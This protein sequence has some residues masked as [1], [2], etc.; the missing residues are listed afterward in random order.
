MSG[1]STLVFAHANGYP[2]G[3]YRPLLDQLAEH[4]R[5][6]A[7]E[8]R[9]LWP[10]ARP[11]AVSTWDVFADDW[12]AWAMREALPPVIGVGH[13]IGAITLLQ[14]A[15]R[16]PERFTALVLLDPVLFTPGRHWL[17]R[18]VRA[19]GLGERLHPLVKAT[20]KR[21]RHFA[22]VA[23]MV[24]RYRRVS[25]FKRIDDRGLLAYAESL[26]APA[27]E[28]GVTLR[29]TPEWEARIYMT[30]APDLW[31]RLPTLKHPALIVAGAES[32]TFVPAAVSRAR[33]ALPQAEVEIV[34]GAGHLVPLEKPNDVAELI[35]GFVERLDHG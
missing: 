7:P 13:S 35:T 22:S 25:V 3:A 28:G 32:D 11:E 23:E 24:G 34:P 15:L 5:V 19:A 10:G 17:W 1:S 21:R 26:A 14:A 27:P 12:L 9:P 30:G 2:P 8:A 18:V 6:L 31:R 33:R 29:F 16:A 20:L 4:H